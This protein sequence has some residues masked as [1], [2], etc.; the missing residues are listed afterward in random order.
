MDHS[1]RFALVVADT[2]VGTSILPFSGYISLRISRLN[3]FFPLKFVAVLPVPL[4]L[5]VNNLVSRAVNIDCSGPRT[6]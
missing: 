4:N 5:A 1:V 6:G 2:V 3:V